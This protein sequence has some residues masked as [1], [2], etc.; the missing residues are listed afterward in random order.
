MLESLEWKH[1]KT[2][3]KV[4]TLCGSTRFMNQFFRSGWDETLDGNI[5]LS[6]GVVV[7]GSGPHQG[8]KFNVKDLLDEIHF[9][10]IDL[11]DE[12]LVLN[13]DGYIGKSTQRE[14]AYA[15]ATHKGMR[16]LEP[17]AGE[18]VMGERSHEIGQQVS[19]FAQGRIPE[20]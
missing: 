1:C 13:V 17:E 19:E 15:T 11:S 12:I 14:M 18:R 8:E 4:V 2:P 20:A 9:R 5:V 6:V 7:D 10:K 16:F 3:P